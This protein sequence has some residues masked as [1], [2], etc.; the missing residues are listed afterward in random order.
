MAIT[1]TWKVD[2]LKVWRELS[3]LTDVVSEVQWQ[4][5]TDDPDR[6][7]FRSHAAVGSTRLNPPSSDTFVPLAQLTEAQVL[8]WAWAA[9]GDVA[10]DAAQRQGWDYMGYTGSTQVQITDLPW[11]TPSETP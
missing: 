10:K 9:M 11:A 3:G 6:T 8:D 2:A 1:Q 7:E 4:I 5:I